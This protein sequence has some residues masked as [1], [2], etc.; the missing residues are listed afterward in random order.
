M[1][2][3]APR[4][5]PLQ[6]VTAGGGRHDL[7]SLL[8]EPVLERGDGDRPALRWSGGWWSYDELAA[9]AGAAAGWLV[10]RGLGRGDIVLV[11][12]DD[13]P[14]WIA[15]FLGA[16]RIGAVV[17]PASPAIPAARRM[18]AAARLGADALVA[19]LPDPRSGRLA[20]SARDLRH[21]IVT[22]VP[23]PG[24]ARVRPDDLAY[25]V[26][27]SG[28]TGPARWARH[29]AGHIPACI[30]TYGRRVLRLRPDDVTWSVASL[31]TSDGLGSLLSLPLGAGAS[32]V[33]ADRGHAPGECAADCAH[34]G[35]TVLLGVPSW[36]ARLV[37]HIDDGREAAERFAGVRMGVSAGEP[38]PAAV[39]EAVHRALGLRL[40]DGLGASEASNVYLSARPGGARP[41]TVGWPVPGYQVRLRRA[42]DP[43]G[44]VPEGELLVRGPTIMDG[45]H[46]EAG[47]GPVDWRGWLATGDVVR[48]EPD[49]CYT[50]LHRTGDR[51]KAGGLWVD[52]RRVTAALLAQEG[53]TD[54]VVI[55][56]ADR[57]GL[58]RVGAAV[59]VGAPLPAG[60]GRL[61]LARAAQR[62]QSHEV[63]RAILV[64][65]ALPT[66]PSGTLDRAE[67]LR[68][69]AGRMAERVA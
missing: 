59:A 53:V 3:A 65:E 45:Y 68:R 63:P 17:A 15:L 32:A 28:A 8:L 34:H 6:A 23:D 56:V 18:A 26:L 57:D 58:L 61:L 22:G 1:D 66:T 62:L 16:S 19:E 52:A 20:L 14:E 2:H 30:A 35:A 36:W 4:R 37:R 9:A 24:P 54:A 44:M 49:G 43:D 38:L 31:S 48:R 5:A 7:P 27:S 51:F 12:L 39:W 67:I 46:A 25:L 13:V 21:A 42:P 10:E 55:P 40:V 50:F 29:R 64:S 69:L 41:G 11:T 47:V 33:L 60:D